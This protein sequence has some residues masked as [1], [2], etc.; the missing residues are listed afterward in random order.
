MKTINLLNSDNSDIKYKI[1]HFPDG[2]YNIDFVNFEID[3]KNE[4][5][6]ISTFRSFDNL[7]VILAT[8][9]I[10][11]GL[12]FS[13]KVT[14]YVPYLLG[15]RSDRKFHKL[16]NSYL[17]QV[18]API[19]NKFNFAKVQSLD[20]HS[21]VAAACINNFESLYF[22]F[23]IKHFA[24]EISDENYKDLTIISPDAG[25]YKKIFKIAEEIG[26]KGDIITCSKYR[27]LKGDLTITVPINRYNSSK[28]LIIDDICDGGRTFV[29]IAQETLRMG[30]QQKSMFLFITHGIF[31]AG[32]SELF[33]NFNKIGTTNSYLGNFKR[34]DSS[35]FSDEKRLISY[36]IYE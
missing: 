21:D 30:V 27:N 4:Y 8:K 5:K 13:P 11:D 16:G 14:L 22:N 1:S 2:Q 36:N 18:L 34:L 20:V 3:E 6:I 28:Y 33:K 15:A 12:V 35:R 31:S 17:V 26:F 32:Y 23:L 25:A 7:Q 29:N 19:L 10:L 24:K 9:A